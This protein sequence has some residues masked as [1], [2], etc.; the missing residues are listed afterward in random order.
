MERPTEE[1][2]DEWTMK[3]KHMEGMKEGRK[4]GRIDRGKEEGGRRTKERKEKLFG[5]T[6]TSPI[7]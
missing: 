5:Y 1:W 2:M 4:E 6:F 7:V 3:K